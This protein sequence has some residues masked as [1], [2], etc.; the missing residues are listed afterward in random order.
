MR[1]YQ[2]QNLTYITSSTRNNEYH[3]HNTLN[4]LS[5][6]SDPQSQPTLIWWPESCSRSIYV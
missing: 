6:R 2:E 1:L 3:N 5:I 4:K